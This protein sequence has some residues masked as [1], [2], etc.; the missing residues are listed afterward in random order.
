MSGHQSTPERQDSGL[1]LFWKGCLATVLA[2]AT[3]TGPVVAQSG[4]DMNDAT[5]GSDHGSGE[6]WQPVAVITREDIET[7]GLTTLDELISDRGD[8]NNFGLRRPLWLGYQILLNGRYPIG[9]LDLVPLSAVD[10]IEVLSNSTAA[11]GDGVASPGTINVVLR[12]DHEGFEVAATGLL[13]QAGGGH[14]GQASLLWGSPMGEGHLVVGVDSLHRGQIPAA[15]RDYSRPKWSEGGSFAGTTGVA[16]GGNTVI[17]ADAGSK[18]QARSLGA[19]LTEQGY[20]GPLNNPA[21][22]EGTGCGFAWANIAW[23]DGPG[24][25]INNKSLLTSLE[26]PLGDASSFYLDGRLAWGEH[27][28]RYAPSVGQFTIENPSQE[29]GNAVSGYTSGPLTVQHR[30]VGHGNRDW[31]TDLD[32]HDVTIGVQGELQ[33]QLAWDLSLNLYQRHEREVG[34]TFV[35]EELAIK[36][37]NAGNY[38][39]IDPLSTDPEHLEA[40]EKTSL[41]MSRNGV[42]DVTTVKA[43]LQRP[44]FSLAGGDTQWTVGVEI[45]NQEAKNIVSH[46]D[47]SG[48]TYP[49]ADV[50]GSGGI[51]YQGE[52]SSKSAFAEVQFPPRPD[53]TVLLAAQYDEHSDVDATHALTVASTWLS[54]ELLSLHGSFRT[55]SNAPSLSDLNSEDAVSY[56][57]VCDTT[58]PQGSLATCDTLQVKEILGSNPNLKPSDFSAWN[59]GAVADLGLLTLAADWFLVENSDL[60]ARRSPQLI[61]DMEAQQ[62]PSPLVKR[63]SGAI[64]EISN[65]LVN[66]GESKLS[67]FSFSGHTAWDTDVVDT[68]LDIHWAY[69]TEN[70]TKVAGVVQPGDFPHHRL[71]AKLGMDWGKL[72]TAWH[73]R[74]ISGYDNVQ[75]SGTFDPWLGHDLTVEFRDVFGMEGLALQ[76]GVLNLTDS[77]PSVDSADPAV[78][79]VRLD[80]VRGRT[81]FLRTELS[82]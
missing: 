70:E 64:T 36:E 26:H 74:F 41:S 31:T 6:L 30:F 3:T 13:P 18:T 72:T 35:S 40:I 77:S 73:T 59:L 32:E 37:I 45:D 38:N 80:S 48:D 46:Q 24:E 1:S 9:S 49:L 2:V 39:L 4:A 21:G 19:C 78:A 75:G 60:P 53:W 7:S 65:P 56:P 52:R 28:H 23:I 10:H 68:G 62:G 69:I 81:F 76:A 43:L 55:G 11:M 58:K 82:W 12:G 67:G 33:N 71:H 47:S 61:V 8:Y 16:I 5:D 25:Q 50:L 57:R 44:G 22:I 54:S 79:D 66:S 17:F 15:E 63:T 51:S 14:T 29:L 27:K 42:V 20:T 34:N